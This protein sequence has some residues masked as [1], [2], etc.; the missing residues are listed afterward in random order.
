MAVRGET[1]MQVSKAVEARRSVRAFLD[2]PVA[3]EKILDL[4][5]QA[6]RAPSGGNLQP[7][8][9]AVLN[10]EAMQRFKGVMEDRLAGVPRPGGDRVE[11]A[12]YPP[13]LKEP[14]RSTRFRVGEQMYALIG[15]AREDRPARLR[16]FANN[17][18]FFGAPAAI[19]CFVDRSMGPPQW[20]DLGMFLQTFMLLAEEAGL[21]TCAQ[22]CW[23]QWPG[24]VGDFCAMD[25]ELMLFCGVAIGHADPAAAVNGLRSEREPL[26]SWVKVL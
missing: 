6:A 25:P 1:R 17:F 4:L 14:Y 8:R 22:E 26:Q 2:K 7:W 12:V 21:G 15:I 19:F 20:S 10:G 13:A 5:A 9:V 16:W 11:Y 23:S 3:T 24:T 18:R